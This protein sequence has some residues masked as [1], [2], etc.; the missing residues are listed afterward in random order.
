MS[1]WIANDAHKQDRI[2]HDKDDFGGNDGD[3]QKR[4]NRAAVC[5]DIY[6]NQRIS[7]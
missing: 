5:I 2:D 6:L 7:T 3:D 4:K 1:A